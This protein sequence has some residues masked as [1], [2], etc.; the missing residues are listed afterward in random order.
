MFYRANGIDSKCSRCGLSN[1]PAIYGQ[2]EVPLSEVLLVVVSAYPSTEEVKQGISLAPSSK[3]L[4]AGAYCR[5]AISAVFD[6]DD[7]FPSTYKPFVMHTF[8]TNMIKC[9]VQLK[10]EKRDIKP[11]HIRSC[12]QWLDTE[13]TQMH[14]EVP[15]L[16]ASSEAVKG[17]LGEGQSL[18][19]NRCRVHLIDKHPGVVTMN[20]IEPSRY[21]TYKANEYK[22]TRGGYLVP[23]SISMEAPS[24]GSVPW[25]FKRDLLATKELVINFIEKREK[26]HGD[27]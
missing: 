9:P 10:K 15:I 23:K 16:I 17:L 2:S 25:F 3:L 4:N 13:L 12:K 20:P 11:N 26:E 7:N 5:K 8:F 1:P 19:T 22:R 21:C 24:I 6:K 18:Y 27:G 14:P